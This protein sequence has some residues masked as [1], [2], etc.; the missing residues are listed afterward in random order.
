MPTTERLGVHWPGSLGR[1]IVLLALPIVLGACLSATVSTYT[2]KTYTSAD[3]RFH[4][5]VPGGAMSD[6]I[7]PS[8]GVFAG[9]TV[10][11]LS[12]TADG[13]R[14]GVV[15]GDAQPT[16]LATTPIDTALANAIS[17][18]VA[19]THGTLI[20]QHPITVGGSP[21]R[22]ARISII[23]GEYLFVVTFAGNRL[24]SLS[25]LGSSDSA[26]RGSEATQFL[27]SFAVTP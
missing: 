1:P 20:E 5:D 23:G 11:G 3:G 8:G 2:L 16:Y 13:L 22:E 25:V 9:S 15:Y 7:L 27:N 4:I 14:F 10:H 17:G 24:Y 12:V 19:S 18:N 21:A 6:T 26:A